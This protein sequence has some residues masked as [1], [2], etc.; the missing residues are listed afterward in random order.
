MIG[1]LLTISCT[2]K[3]PDNLGVT[4][5]RLTDCPSRPNCVNSQAA[6]EGHFVP[7]FTYTKSRQ[8]AFDRLKKAVLS[9]ERVTIVEEKEDYLRVEF[10]SALV[11]FVDDVEFY[12]PE[13][14]VIHVRSASRIG[15]SDLGVNR[16]RVEH[17][18]NLFNTESPNAE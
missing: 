14:K 5:D 16:K 18:R 6:D 1:C 2:G 12:F 17:I 4:G 9:C 13:E 7:E 15:Y 11:R 8:A 10:K 3:R